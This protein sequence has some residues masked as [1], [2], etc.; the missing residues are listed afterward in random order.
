VLG[1]KE[2][3]VASLARCTGGNIEAEESIF[4]RADTAKV[5]CRGCLGGRQG[6]DGKNQM[7]KLGVMVLSAL[8]CV[9]VA[10][11]SISWIVCNIYVPQSS[12]VVDLLLLDMLE[13]VVML[14]QRKADIHSDTCRPS[15]SHRHNPAG[16]VV[17]NCRC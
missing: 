14:M 6:G 13:V 10:M 1:K 11:I 2:D 17:P 3:E 4:R 15:T 8:N 5:G 16:S 9:L 12:L 7:R